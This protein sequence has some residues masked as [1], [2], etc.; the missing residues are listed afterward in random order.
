M[1]FTLH[2]LPDE[3]VDSV[4][5]KFLVMESGEGSPPLLKRKEGIVR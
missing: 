5:L 2:F 1:H 3:T 4:K